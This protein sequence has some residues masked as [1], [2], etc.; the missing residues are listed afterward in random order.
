MKTDKQV[1]QDVIAALQ[2]EPTVDAKQFDVTVENGLVTL[3]GDVGSYVEKWDAGRATQRVQG[4]R[5]L[6]CELSVMLSEANTRND[7]DI[8]S[9]AANVLQWMS[10][11]PRNC[12]KLAVDKAWITLSGEVE[13]EF[14]R[15]AVLGT[16]RFLIGIKGVT[17]TIAVKPVGAITQAANGAIKQ[18]MTPL[19]VHATSSDFAAVSN[20]SGALNI[21]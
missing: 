13:W 14:Q 9:A 8:A 21:A 5:G 17:E 6:R 10:Y 12:V 20:D 3:R 15:Q 19:T 4:V 11:L 1:R 16:V 7:T 2:W 18:K